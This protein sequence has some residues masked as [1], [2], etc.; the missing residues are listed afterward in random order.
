V[1]ERGIVLGDLH[2][3]NVLV[4]ADGQIVLIDLE[5]ASHV[6]EKLRPTLADPGF[7]SP[8]GVMG[9]DIDLYALACLRLFNVLAANAVDCARSSEGQAAR[10]RDRPAV[11]E[12]PGRV[13]RRRGAGDH[14]RA[15][16]VKLDWRSGAEPRANA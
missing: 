11:P 14:R 8:P 5:I 12:R 7:A 15:G 6:S 4:Q 2:P 3:S 9:F 1:H 10:R 16:A 13:S